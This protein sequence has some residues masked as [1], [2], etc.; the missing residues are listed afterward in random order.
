MLDFAKEMEEVCP[1]AWLLN[2]TNPM[3][4][5]T[6]GV[7]KATSIKTVG[8]CHSVQVCVPELFEHLGIAD[9][10]DLND[11]QWKIAG[12]NHMAFLLEITK[13]GEDFYPTIRQL[14]AEKPNPHPDSVRFELLKR[15]G[16]YITES[17]EHNAEYHP[18]FIKSKYPE[19]IDELGFRWMNTYVVVN[20]KLM[21]GKACERTL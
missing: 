20:N 7:L 4:M 3:A 6:M 15:F 19:L 2:Y 21:I 9:Q 12:I 11:F 18:Y 10:Y 17:S 16:Y 5:L 1:N 13:N 14:A 8:L